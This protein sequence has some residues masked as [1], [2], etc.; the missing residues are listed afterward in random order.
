MP[1]LYTPTAFLARY[2]YVRDYEINPATNHPMYRV[3]MWLDK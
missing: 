1:F 3:E 2:K